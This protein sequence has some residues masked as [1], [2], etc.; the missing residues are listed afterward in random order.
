MN[1]NGIPR[2]FSQYRSDR[3]HH[4]VCSIVQS[5][6]RHNRS[7][8]DDMLAQYEARHNQQQAS[9]QLMASTHTHTTRTAVCT[10]SCCTHTNC[11]LPRGLSACHTYIPTSF[12]R[13]SCELKRTK[14]EKLTL[15][16]RNVRIH[17]VGQR[18]TK[19]ATRNPMDP[20]P[21][22]RGFVDTFL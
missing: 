9:V 14:G 10:Q 2:S 1:S 19:C 5:K 22:S 7:G 6:Y 12:V 20:Q 17:T 13:N 16:L 21:F 18:F 3:G 15:F 4:L 8:K 11:F